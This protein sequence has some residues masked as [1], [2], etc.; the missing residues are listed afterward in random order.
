MTRQRVNPRQC[1]KVGDVVL[2]RWWRSLPDWAVDGVFAA[3]LCVFGLVPALSVYGLNL[4]ELP[5][6]PSDGLHLLLIAGQSLPLAARRSRPGAVLA[7]IGL[8]FALDQCRGYPPSIAGLGI[9]FALYSAGAHLRRARVMTA[10]ASAAAYVMLAI[11]L[12]LLGSPDHAWDFATFVVVLIAA[13]LLGDFVRL[14]A[15]AARVRGGEA[16]RAAVADERARLARELHDVVSHHVTG[17]VVQADAAGFIVPEDQVQVSEQFASI[18][19]GGRRALA[20]L[21]RLLDVLAADD[22]SRA[23]A[24]GPLDDLAAGARRAG[25]FVELHES[26]TPSGSDELRLA[27]YRIVQ[28]GLTN[29]R[30]HADGTPTEVD[31][32]WSAEAVAVRVT[33]SSTDVARQSAPMV[34]GSGRGLAGLAERVARLGGRLDAG[35]DGDGAFVLAAH[36]SI[37]LEE[38]PRG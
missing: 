24:I 37:A 33:S 15:A 34:P 17:M 32:E 8:A 27:V 38:D 36:I 23:P 26:G 16:S 29:A 31:V 20:D 11:A 35:R 18:A 25:Q 13:W 19:D 3:I 28:E 5:T 21:R 12:S 9:V 22:T 30:K 6:R 7:V 1:F 10:A 14:R 4:G 2:V